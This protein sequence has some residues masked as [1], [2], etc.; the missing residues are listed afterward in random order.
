MKRGNQ[1]MNTHL[2]IRKTKKIKKKHE[3]AQLY[4]KLILYNIIIHDYINAITIFIEKKKSEEL[5]TVRAH[6]CVINISF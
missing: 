2:N 5:K 6:Y 4:S 1:K 3:H